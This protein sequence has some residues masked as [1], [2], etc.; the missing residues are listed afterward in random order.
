MKSISDVAQAHEVGEDFLFCVAEYTSDLIIGTYQN[1][2]IVYANRSASDVYGYSKEEFYSMYFKDLEKLGNDENLLKLS[3]EG[4]MHYRAMHRSKAGQRISVEVKSRRVNLSEGQVI[5]NFIRAASP[6]KQQIRNAPESAGALEP[7]NEADNVLIILLDQEGRIT[8]LNQ[9]AQT[10][11]GYSFEEAVGHDGIDLLVPPELVKIIKNYFRNYLHRG[12]IATHRGAIITKSGE[13]RLIY[14]QNCIIGGHCDMQSMLCIGMDVKDRLWV[15]G[16]LRKQE[17]FIHSVVEGLGFSFFVLDRQYRY[18]AFNEN[19]KKGA[20]AL[21]NADIELGMDVLALHVNPDNKVIAKAHFDKALA[22]E[23]SVL[24]AV[25]GEAQCET[26]PVLIEHNPVRDFKGNVVGV[27]VAAHNLSKLRKAEAEAASLQQRYKRLVEAVPAII[28]V[29]SNLGKIQY[30]N[31]YGSKIFRF[32]PEELIGRL[33]EE[34][35]FPEL[36]STGQS[37][38][39]FLRTIWSG[40]FG[41]YKFTGENISKQGQHIWIQWSIQEGISPATGETGWLCM[42]IDVTEKHRAI[43]MEMRKQKRN[44]QNEIMYDVLSGRIS[45]EQIKGCMQNLGIDIENG[46]LC[47]AIA[48]KGRPDAIERSLEERQDRDRLL[49]RCRS[50][51]GGVVW[52][53]GEFMGVLI[54]YIEKDRWKNTIKLKEFALKKWKELQQC[55]PERIESAGAAFKLYPDVGIKQLWFHARSALEF[56]KIL[57]SQG[58]FHLWNELG[59]LRLLVQNVRSTESTQFVQEHLGDLLTI[60]DR[61]KRQVLLETLRNFLDGKSIE[62]IAKEMNVHHQTVRYR[63]ALLKKKFGVDGLKGERKINISTALRIYQIQN[64]QEGH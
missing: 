19:H 3:P 22:G 51:T 2:K 16:D 27:S 52:D 59:W 61:E 57:N 15:E 47:F 37:F 42:G 48:C 17:A 44:R 28:L 32:T 63:I 12:Y 62:E 24:E 34:S 7:L 60:S 40:S 36:D 35:I 21:F 23:Q 56:G 39:K 46:L 45:D 38:W 58:S 9:A 20:K 5:V 14:W 64:A 6:G 26:R 33:V 1:G 31:P 55:W 13:R 43:E 53:A 8:F 41:D 30:I 29:V 11:T 10:I 25:V 4:G 50:L 54:P 18:L 49:D